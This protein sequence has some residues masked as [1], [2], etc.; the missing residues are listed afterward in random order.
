MTAARARSTR[1][2]RQQSGIGVDPEET[3]IRFSAY[4]ILA[5]VEPAI[6]SRRRSLCG[7]S[8]S[9]RVQNVRTRSGLLDSRAPAALRRLCIIR[10]AYS[11]SIAEALDGGR[12]HLHVGAGVADAQVGVE[13]AMM[14][15]PSLPPSAAQMGEPLHRQAAAGAQ[16]PQVASHGKGE[17]RLR[18]RRLVLGHVGRGEGI[19]AGIDAHAPVMHAPTPAPIHW[20][21]LSRRRGAPVACRRVTAAL[22]S[23][24]TLTLRTRLAVDVLDRSPTRCSALHRSP[25]RVVGVRIR[26]LKQEE[27]LWIYGFNCGAMARFRLSLR[28]Q[29]SHGRCISRGTSH[30]FARITGPN[31]RAIVTSRHDAHRAHIIVGARSTTAT[32]LRGARASAAPATRN[33]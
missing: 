8:A 5:V 13:E 7:A 6:Q 22:V 17:L 4:S 15:T 26:A 14:P 10:S 2:R 3:A 20:R 31:P 21:K 24:D 30:T 9:T 11:D 19:S 27:M 16:P 23:A 33:A 28:D 12:I 1:G 32:M 18:P 29:C 25:S